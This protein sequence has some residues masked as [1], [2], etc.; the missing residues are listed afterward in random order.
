MDNN[1]NRCKDHPKSNSEGRKIAPLD[2]DDLGIIH[3]KK[4]G[5][6]KHKEKDHF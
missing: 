6:P 3:G 4:V 2:N 1:K 5:A